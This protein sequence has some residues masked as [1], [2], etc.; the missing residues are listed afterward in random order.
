MCKQVALH[1]ELLTETGA[2][3]FSDTYLCDDIMEKK[4]F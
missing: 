4:N 3:G 1:G 2:A